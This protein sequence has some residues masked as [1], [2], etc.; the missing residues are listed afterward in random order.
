MIKSLTK[1]QIKNLYEITHKKKYKFPET[2]KELL[3]LCHVEYQE[4][5]SALENKMKQN[6]FGLFKSAEYF[7]Y[8]Q[9][10]NNLLKDDVWDLQWKLEHFEECYDKEMSKSYLIDIDDEDCCYID[11][12]EKTN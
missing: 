6:D 4:K 11:K 9:M 2:T 8:E 3:K 12:L 10:K 7:V 1:Y 5:L